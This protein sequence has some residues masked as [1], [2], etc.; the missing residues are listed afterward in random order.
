MRPRGLRAL[1]LIALCA[2]A[3]GC[4]RA[5]AQS[6]D[7]TLTLEVGGRTRT[8][9]LHVPPGYTAGR[10]TPLVLLLHGGG[11]NGAQAERAYDQRI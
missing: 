10:P 4:V 6:G 11:G 1:P 3:L 7:R 8:A 9:I 5:G 2:V